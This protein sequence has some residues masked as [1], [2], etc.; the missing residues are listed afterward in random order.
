M[1]ATEETKKTKDKSVSEL[2]TEL[3]K[4]KAKLAD[5]KRD[6]ALDKL[7][8]TSD[9]KKTKK[10]IAKIQTIMRE[11]LEAELE[12]EEIKEKNVE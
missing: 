9:I 5:L 10:Y 7:K 1:K 8:K 6:L 11:K 12:K 4:A 3:A 2:V